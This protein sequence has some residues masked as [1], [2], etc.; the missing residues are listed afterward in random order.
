MKSAKPGDRTQG[1][2]WGI[3]SNTEGH[4][5]KQLE[6]EQGGKVE[7]EQ[8]GEEKHGEGDRVQEMIQDCCLLVDRDFAVGKAIVRG[9]MDDNF[10]SWVPVEPGSWPPS[11]CK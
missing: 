8:G 5:E 7:G 11:L 10:L 4:R 1:E 3:G 2:K 6:R 9:W